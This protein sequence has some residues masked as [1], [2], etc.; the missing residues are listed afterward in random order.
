MSKGNNF[1]HMEFISKCNAFIFLF[2]PYVLHERYWMGPNQ[3]YQKNI[4]PKN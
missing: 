1:R 2:I 3:G 4:F